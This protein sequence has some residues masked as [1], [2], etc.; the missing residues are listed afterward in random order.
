[1][2]SYS[3]CFIQ[4]KSLSCCRG[5]LLMSYHKVTQLQSRAII[6]TKQTIKAMNNG[7]VSELFIA[8]DAD[9]Q[10]TLKVIQSAKQSGVPYTMLH[11]K[12]QLGKACNIE[13]DATAVAI[14]KENIE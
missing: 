6:G 3:R 14:R 2:I 13:V 7:E 5:G 10:V 11:S 9:K 4:M 1:M 12:K 8:E